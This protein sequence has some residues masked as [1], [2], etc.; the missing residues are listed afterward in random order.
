MLAPILAP[1]R[2]TVA[3]STSEGDS[4]GYP[5]P[6][7]RRPPRR[8][9][10][11]RAIPPL[12]RMYERIELQLQRGELKD[13][14][15]PMQA[16]SRHDGLLFVEVAAMNATHRPSS[17][18]LSRGPS[19][20]ASAVRET[21]LLRWFWRTGPWDDHPPTG[22]SSPGEDRRSRTETSETRWGVPLARGGRARRQPSGWPRLDSTHT[23]SFHSA[24]IENS[25]PTV[26]T[27]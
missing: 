25:G 1:C 4:V 16:V 23:A 7:D 5:L 15:Q 12:Q 13:E 3:A 19:R 10:L 2:E 21:L 26:S 17:S 24:C 20:A 27:R 22:P 11:I 14:C 18:R 8:P 9:R 6:A